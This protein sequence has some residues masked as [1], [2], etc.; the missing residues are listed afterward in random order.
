MICP[1]QQRDFHAQSHLCVINLWDLINFPSDLQRKGAGRE[2]RMFRR[3]CSYS[4]QKIQCNVFKPPTSRENQ[5]SSFLCL[6]TLD[7]WSSGVVID[8][9][10]VLFFFFLFSFK[11]SWDPAEKESG[12]IIKTMIKTLPLLDVWSGVGGGCKSVLG[13][14][15]EQRDR[16]KGE[17][18]HKYQCS[19]CWSSSGTRAEPSG[20]VHWLL[21]N[22]T[23][24]NR[25]EEGELSLEMELFFCLLSSVL[26]S[27]LQ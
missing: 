5:E 7:F 10:T 20:A 2:W 21:I 13:I 27:V 23:W 17:L 8:P 6:G 15:E 4:F 3:L 25:G 14:G 26:L 24:K 16:G 18:N 9:L 11:C 1:K 22:S 19:V 12:A